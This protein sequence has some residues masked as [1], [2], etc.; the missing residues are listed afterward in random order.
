MAYRF[1]LNEPVGRGVRRILTEQID[2]TIAHITAAAGDDLTTAVHESRKCLKRARAL[3]RFARPQLSDDDFK[4]ANAVLR[5]VGRALSTTRDL[6]VLGHTLALLQADDALKPAT[7]KKLADAISTARTETAM[8]H[9]NPEGRAALA[10]QLTTLR[11]QV[12]D[13]AIEADDGCLPTAGLAACLTDCR[14]AYALAFES[15]R[16]EAFHDWRKSIQLHWRQMQLVHRA[17]PNYAQARIEEAR[18]ISML[19]GTDRDLLMLQAF[20]AAVPLSK[21]MQSEVAHHVTQRTQALR[22]EAKARGDRLLAEGTSG[23]CR[24]LEAYWSAA[25]EIRVAGES[26]EQG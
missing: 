16:D 2:R 6:D 12:G 3:L 11:A 18:A 17:W 22:A 26:D 25:R 20:A 23:F 8:Q 24:R 13:L 7:L 5:D 19:I 21:G 15:K 1:K 14:K 9:L 4:N 10:E